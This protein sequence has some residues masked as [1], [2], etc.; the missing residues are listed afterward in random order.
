M[1][2]VKSGVCEPLAEPSLRFKYEPDHFQNHSFRAIE[3]G[4]HVLVTAHTGSGKTSV[5]EYSVAYALKNS[6][7]VIYTAPI[8]ALSNQ[9]YGDFHKKYPE[10]NIGIKTGDIDENSEEADVVIMTTEILRNMLVMD[11]EGTALD[12]V[13]VVVFDEVHWIKDE[14]RGVVWEESI[15]MM[16]GHVQMI[17]LSAT[18]P[19]AEEF[20]TWVAVCK[21]KDVTYTTTERRVVPL[22]HYVMNTS[23]MK[24]QLVLDQGGTFISDV[25]DKN[26]RGYNFDHRDINS[27]LHLVDFPALFFCFSRRRCELYAGFVNSDLLVDSQT[28]REIDNHYERLVRKYDDTSFQYLTQAKQVHQLLLKGVCFHHSGLLPA[29][30]EIVQEIFALGLLKILFVTETF[31]AGVNLPAKTVV[32]TGFSKMDSTIGDFRT[33]YHEEYNQMAG[34]AGRRGMDTSG[35]VILWNFCGPW[36]STKAAR[37][38]ANG[39]VRPIVSRMNVDYG[40]VLRTLRQ[41]TESLNGSNVLSKSL[42]TR[43]EA[44]SLSASERM[45]QEFD[46]DI[47]QLRK[48][49]ERNTLDEEFSQHYEA[50]RKF[51]SGAKMNK[52]ELKD[53]RLKHQDYNERHVTKLNIHDSMLRKLETCLLEKS[54]L[55]EFIHNFDHRYDS[56]FMLIQE[57]IESHL[58][59]DQVRVELACQVNECNPFVLIKLVEN[60]MLEHVGIIQ[61]ITVLSCLIPFEREPRILNETR[62]PVSFD[63]EHL[64]LDL[65]FNVDTLI[66]DIVNEEQR[67]GIQNQSADWNVYDRFFPLVNHWLNGDNFETVRSKSNIEIYEGEFVRNM[68]RL[69]NV[70][71]EAYLVAEGLKKTQLCE[72]L[73]DHQSLVVRDIVTPQSLYV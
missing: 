16:P 44:R 11:T 65:L 2:H 42:L 30:K 50:F 33:L 12:S 28:S 5:A 41:N 18:L 31:A 52:K 7:R 47:D 70:C 55:Q 4:H 37:E 67:M 48:S 40:F 29:L 13:G 8:K 45:F 32:F 35:T 46:D 53:Y 24:K 27:Y 1:I 72:M 38:M 14:S 3:S 71:K 17:M 63:D 59:F 68:L 69:N 62:E 64:V 9:I 66:A 21:G 49:I 56:Q 58:E 20:G 23:A 15:I 6:K 10:W 60:G 22:K 43:Q 26:K 73:R 57:F 51:K 54:E 34:R 36:P 39:S 19:D 61:L 25:Y